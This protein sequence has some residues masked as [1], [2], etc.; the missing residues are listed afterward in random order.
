MHG[1]AVAVLEQRLAGQLPAAA[2]QPHQACIV[3]ARFQRLAT[4]AA[5]GEAHFAAGDEARMHV[6]Q[7]GDAVGA[8]GLLVAGVAHA[9]QGLPQQGHH[10]RHDLAARKPWQCQVGADA[11]AQAGQ[12]VGEGEQAVV[13]ACTAFG[14][15]LVVRAAK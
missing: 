6:A 4:L 15:S 14:V 5:E 3:D 13:L 1:V 12:G 11:S 8:V 7:R 10:Q 2:H 9:Q